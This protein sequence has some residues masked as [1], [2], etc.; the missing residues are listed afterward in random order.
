MLSG[1]TW[2]DYLKQFKRLELQH[3]IGLKGIMIGSAPG[4]ADSPRA[5]I[6]NMGALECLRDIDL[7]D[8]CLQ[9]ATSGDCMQHTRWCRS[10]TGEEYARTYSW[11]NDPKR[12]VYGPASSAAHLLKNKTG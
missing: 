3:F 2:Y 12:M 1:F 9:A 11:G 8:E 6:Q 4:S 10:M 7:E 5:H